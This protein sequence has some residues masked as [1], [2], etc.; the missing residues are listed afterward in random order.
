MTID[1]LDVLQSLQNYFYDRAR[2]CDSLGMKAE[3]NAY[4]DSARFVSIML[5]EV[6]PAPS[7]CKYL[8]AISCPTEGEECKTPV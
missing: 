2:A 7:T 8:Q 1:T 5:H 4:R 3:A 6:I